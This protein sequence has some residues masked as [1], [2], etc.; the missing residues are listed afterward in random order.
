[1]QKIHQTQKAGNARLEFQQLAFSDEGSKIRVNF[2]RL[3][4]FYLDK[5][6]FE[7][8]AKFE[9]GSNFVKFE[10]I[11]SKKAGAKFNRLL[12]KGFLEL[13]NA[14]NG[15]KTVYVHRNSGIPLIGNIAFGIVDR[16]TSLIE[17]KPFTSCNIK[18]IYCSVDEDKRPVDFVIERDY[19][20]EELKKLIKLKECGSIEV[21]IASQGEPT[22]YAELIPLIKDIKKIKEVKTISIFT[23]ST[24]LNEKIVDELIDAGLNRINISINAMNP[25][26]ARKIAGANYSI[27]HVRKIAEYITGRRDCKFLIAPVWIPGI[28][29][30]ELDSIA[31]F[32]KQLRQQNEKVSLGI[33]NFLNYRFGRNPVKEQPL[34]L[35]YKKLKELEIKHGMK[36]IADETEFN[37]IKTKKLPSPFKKNEIVKAQLVCIGRLANE[38]IAVARNRTISVFGYKGNPGNPDSQETVKIRILRTKHNIFAGEAVH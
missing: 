30:S 12:A 32:V 6:D 36:L 14:L 27:S 8:I 23:N 10:N 16:N 24:L 26:T 19:L 35:F 7:R 31:E 17:V 28:N 5:T 18:C 34:E 11:D 2:L 25:E 9:I 33:Q 21:N 3:F 38:A 1:M 4:Y 37:I 13:R 29:D 15:K 22:L 20:V